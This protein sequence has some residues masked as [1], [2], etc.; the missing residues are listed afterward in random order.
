MI[1]SIEHD[2]KMD[3]NKVLLSAYSDMDR[4][5]ALSSLGS[6]LSFFTFGISNVLKIPE[7]INNIKTT[8]EVSRFTMDYPKNHL[9]PTLTYCRILTLNA[10]ENISPLTFKMLINFKEVDIIF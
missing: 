9:I 8:K 1:L 5:T 4:Y 10:R 7:M 6:V 2:G 3:K